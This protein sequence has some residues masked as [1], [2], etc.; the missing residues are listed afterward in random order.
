MLQSRNEDAEKARL[1]YYFKKQEEHE[2][3]T[4]P[5]G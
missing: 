5:H 4:F 2:V 3:G 1:A